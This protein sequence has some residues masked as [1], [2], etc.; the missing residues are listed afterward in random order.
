MLRNPGLI[1]FLDG[2][3]LSIPNHFGEE[4]PTG[5]MLV[6]PGNTDESLLRCGVAVEKMLSTLC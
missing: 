2:C 4:P 3:A 5:L 6:S 1:N